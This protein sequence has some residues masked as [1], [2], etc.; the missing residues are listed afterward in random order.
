MTPIVDTKDPVQRVLLVLLAV[1][2]SFLAVTYLRPDLFMTQ[3]RPT[4]PAS[5]SAPG[6]KPATIDG[7]PVGLG[8]AS[9]SAPLATPAAGADESDLGTTAAVAFTVVNTGTEPDRLLGAASAIGGDAVVAERSGEGHDA[10]THPLANGLP[11][12]AGASVALDPDGTHLLLTGITRP[13]DKGDTF[14]VTL[15]FERAGEVE[16]PV[17]VRKSAEKAQAHAAAPVA[18]GNL[19]IENAWARAADTPDRGSAATPRA[20]SGHDKDAPP[21]DAR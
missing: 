5:A 8:S 18:I 11:I 14:L 15:R 17:Q 4:A 16:V 9:G 2:V 20:G 10:V 3:A 7:G 12:P 21:A 19:R 1:A 13:E 6:M